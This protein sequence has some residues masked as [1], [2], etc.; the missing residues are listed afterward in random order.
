M[1]LRAASKHSRKQLQGSKAVDMNQ[2][3]KPELL[4]DSAGASH[5][6]EETSEVGVFVGVLA[7]L[8]HPIQSLVQELEWI[9]PH[10]HLNQMSLF[11]LKNV[12]RSS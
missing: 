1:A 6:Q 10:W 4:T 5:F 7:I 11:S 9:L 2:S 8:F 12:I 3:I